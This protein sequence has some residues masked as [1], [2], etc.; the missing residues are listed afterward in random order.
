MGFLAAQAIGEIVDEGQRDHHA[1]G[2]AD[3]RRRPSEEAHPVA[4][5]PRPDGRAGH[6]EIE[7]V[8]APASSRACV[9]NPVWATMR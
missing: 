6:E 7:E 4:K 9:R 2:Q 8:H 3:P 1:G 5:H